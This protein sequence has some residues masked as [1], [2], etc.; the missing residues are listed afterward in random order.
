MHSRWAGCRLCYARA[1][2]EDMLR[3][4]LVAIISSALHSMQ[5]VVPMCFS[6]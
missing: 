4:N 2:A 3:K 5:H 6:L 1:I